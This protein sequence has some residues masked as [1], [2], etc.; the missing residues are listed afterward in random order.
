MSDGNETRVRGS[1]ETECLLPTRRISRRSLLQAGSLAGLGLDFAR[2]LGAEELRGISGPQAALKANLKSCILIFCDG[3][4]SHIDTFDMKPDAP[5]EVRGEF[6][7][8]S[9]SVPGHFVSEHLP[10]TARLMHRLAIVRSMRHAMRGHRSGV[11]N[12]LCGL[13]PP[14]GDVC[15]IPPERQQL[16]SYG[17]RL[18]YAMKEQKLSL[19]HV[20]LPY[21][22]RDGNFVLPGQTA[23]FLGPAYQPFRV[24]HNP[25]L[26]DIELPVLNLPADMSLDR[27]EHR[28]S[29]LDIIT[30][31]QQHLAATESSRRMT[32]CQRQAFTMLGAGAVRRAFDLSQEPLPSRD[33]YGRNIVGQSV[34]LARRLVEAE[35]RFVTVNIGSQENEWYWDDH[36]QVFSGHKTRLAP[37]DQSFSALID[38]LVARGLSDSTMVV[39]LGEFGRT[40]KINKDVGRDHWPDCYCAVFAGGGVRQGE[41]YGASDRIGAYPVSDPVGPADLAATLFWRFGLDPAAEMIDPTGRP[42]K[43]AEGTPVKGLFA[44]IA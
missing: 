9:T 16:P 39:A 20:M 17:A 19:P 25:K 2:P 37:F 44:A 4:P 40:P 10:L 31:Q 11:T 5:A 8:I 1:S 30:A 26:P 41:Y 34:L 33:R 27:L 7:P 38:D 22:A 36:K 29:L 21:A 43:L 23:G 6:L 14:A 15:D 18:A 12:T 35:V 32:T 13:P 42:Y 24:D 3:G 28:E